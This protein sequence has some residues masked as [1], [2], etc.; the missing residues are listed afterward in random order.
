MWSDVLR[1][2]LVF[3]A[4]STI[5]LGLAYPLAITGVAQVAFP[6][7]ANGSLVVVERRAL[8]SSLVGQSFTSDRYF[9]GRPS[10]TSARPYDAASSTGSNLGPLH[11][12]LLDGVKSR[13]EAV[14]R[15][16]GHDGAIPVELVTASGSGL[17]PHVSPASA[18]LQ[19]AR[20][21]R[22]RGLPEAEL[23]ALVERSVEPRLFG[24]FGAPRVN[25]L[26][27]NLALDRR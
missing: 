24:L 4:A 23:R 18:L 1:P 7:Q 9:H 17:D 11:P 26:Q 21:A 2:S 20:V 16:E 5:L 14:R 15:R 22:A 10:A 12:Q 6:K 19:V 27:L 25:V 13:V 8:G 3:V